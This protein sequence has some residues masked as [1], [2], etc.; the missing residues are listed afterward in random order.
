MVSDTVAVGVLTFIGTVLATLTGLW[1]WRRVQAREQRDEFGVQRL[2]AL[3][4]MW[5]A[6]SS[7]LNSTSSHSKTAHTDRMI[8]S[9][10]AK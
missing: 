9:I 10:R 6:L 1:R 8:S 2:E 7:P 5:E 4:E 3:K